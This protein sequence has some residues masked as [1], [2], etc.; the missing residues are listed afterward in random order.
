MWL[1]TIGTMARALF[2]SWA[3]TLGQRTHVP[4]WSMYEY[5]RHH[6]SGTLRSR[7]VR[8]ADE[9]TAAAKAFQDEM[10]RYSDQPLADGRPENAY[11]QSVAHVVAKLR[12]VSD[13]AKA[14]D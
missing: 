2:V 10:Q 6:T 7:I 13:A 5:Y 14:W 8:R 9:L 1:T 3:G 12:D 4:L 11:Q